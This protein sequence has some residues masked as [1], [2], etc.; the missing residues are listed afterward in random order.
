MF[1]LIIYILLKLIFIHGFTYV[2]DKIRNQLRGKLFKF[3]NVNEC[4]L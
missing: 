1:Y 3:K 2:F 4:N